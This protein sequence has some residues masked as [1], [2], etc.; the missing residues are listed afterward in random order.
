[1]SYLCDYGCCGNQVAPYLTT[2]KQ[3]FGGLGWWGRLFTILLC[4]NSIICQ[5]YF[6]CSSSSGFQ[7][8]IYFVSS[9]IQKRWI[10]FVRQTSCIDFYIQYS[11][12]NRDFWLYW[13]GT[14]TV[15]MF[16]SMQ[17]IV[18]PR[19]LFRSSEKLVWGE[20]FSFHQSCHT[21]RLV[22]YLSHRRISLTPRH[23]LL[24]F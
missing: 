18:G 19:Y 7:G 21:Y 9:E 20:K 13:N 17:C 6:A 15:I 12:W 1:M 24:I 3:A 23:A 11:Y 22:N 16:I 10:E 8:A 5:N 14:T 2:W 4:Q